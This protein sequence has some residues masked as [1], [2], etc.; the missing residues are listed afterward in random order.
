M[1]FVPFLEEVT[2][3]Q[4]CFEIN[5]PLVLM[6]HLHEIALL[7]QYYTICSYI[8]FTIK[9]ESLSKDT[10]WPK[11]GLEKQLILYSLISMRLIY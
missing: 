6:L 2:A 10:I 4:L 5:R 9:M 7:T 11:S 3:R 1:R 8:V